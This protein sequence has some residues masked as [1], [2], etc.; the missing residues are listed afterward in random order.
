MANFN[1]NTGTRK[2][3]HLNSYETGIICVLL[4]EGKSIRYIAR[5]L[6][7]EP[8]TISREIKRRT[9]LQLKSNLETYEDYFPETG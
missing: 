9:A 8:S 5:Q 6:G 1:C 7:R 3:E 4:N 2:F